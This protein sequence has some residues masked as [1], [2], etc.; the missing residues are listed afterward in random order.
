MESVAF[1]QAW[2]TRFRA[3]LKQAPS[4]AEL[5]ESETLQESIQDG[6]PLIQLVQ[7]EVPPQLFAEV[8]LELAELVASHQPAVRAEAQLVAAALR[9][10]GHAE[11]VELAAAALDGTGEAVVALAGRIGVSGDLLYTLVG[12]ALQ[13]FFAQFAR[14]L[15]K[16]APVMMWRH[17]YCPI[18]GNVPDV[19]RIDPD[20]QRH[21]HCPQCDIQWLHH[22][23][24]CVVCDTDD[25]KKV[26]LLTIADLEPWRVEVCDECNGYIKTLDQRHGGLKAQLSVDLFVEDART[27]QLDLMAQEKGYRRGGRLQ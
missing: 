9:R 19:A 27:V 5:P 20:N 26:Q 12:L 7:P 14:R 8:L 17:N 4:P 15:G 13:P 6:E 18:C 21:L 11:R 16:A 1:I 22:R 25:I 2:R 24:T 23:L 10:A 3:L